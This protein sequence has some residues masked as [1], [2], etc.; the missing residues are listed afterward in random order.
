[1]GTGTVSSANDMISCTVLTGS[2]IWVSLE[3]Q[4]CHSGGRK[5]HRNI[6]GEEALML[7]GFPTQDATLKGAMATCSNAF[8]Q[9]LAGNAFPST[10]VAAFV[11]AILFALSEGE[12]LGKRAAAAEGD[13]VAMA[14][15]LLKKARG[16]S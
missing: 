5:I 8:L 2:D 10:V 15:S 16:S 6:I 9:H 13:D 1:M 7:N 4:D 11:I 14:M 3:P 12:K